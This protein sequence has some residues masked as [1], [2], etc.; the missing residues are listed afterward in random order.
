MSSQGRF[1]QMVVTSSS[2]ADVA[3]SVGQIRAQIESSK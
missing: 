3:T 2:K 1:L